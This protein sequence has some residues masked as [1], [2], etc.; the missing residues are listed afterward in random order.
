MALLAVLAAP[1]AALATDAIE[2]SHAAVSGVLLANVRAHT[3][4][5]LDVNNATGD[6]FVRATPCVSGPDF[7]AMGVHFI[8]IERLGSTNPPTDDKPTALIYE[9]TATG[10]LRFVGVEFIV[11]A[12]P[13]DLAHPKSPPSLDGNLFNL[14]G[15]PN[16][17]GLDAFY[18]LHVWAWQA[19]PAGN[20]ADWNTRVVCDHQP[21]GG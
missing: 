7:G 11:M 5:Y 21:A 14:V 8:K 17:F 20:F 4:R 2:H 10:A 12:G 18:E 13:W 3:A 9:P 19:N 6:G 16:R 1:V 15:S